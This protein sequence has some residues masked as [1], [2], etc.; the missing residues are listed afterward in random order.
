M[1]VSSVGRSS[2][3][4]ESGRSDGSSAQS[5]VSRVAGV[6][7]DVGGQQIEVVLDDLLGHRGWT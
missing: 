3:L 2:S 6:L 5:I 1:R 7:A 4:A